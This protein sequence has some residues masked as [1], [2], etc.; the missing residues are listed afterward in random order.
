MTA[1]AVWRAAYALG[2]GL[3]VDEDRD[4]VRWVGPDA[5]LHETGLH[6]Y[7]G[8]Y[9]V[10]GLYEAAYYLAL[11]G[12]S[13]RLLAEVLGEVVP[14]AE[15]AGRRVL[16]VGAGTGTVGEALARC[17]FGPVAGVDLEPASERALRRD[18][19]EVYDRA[20]TLDLRALT[21][22]DERW[23][24]AVGPDVVTVAGAVGF[25]HLPVEAFAVLTSLLPQDGLLA[26]TA[27]R[28][29]ATDPA[30]AGHAALLLGPSYDLVSR[31]E[32]VHRRSRGGALEVAALV[33]RRRGDA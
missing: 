9:A 1:S 20:R 2:D 32:G 6:D 22:D 13:P 8:L 30:L 11:E 7:A 28:D 24:T 33:L 25:G 18:R 17:G 12:R 10:P 26:L 29:L 19:P 31:R 23:L 5:S 16:D 21:P 3:V 14:E 4:V 27:A 15:R